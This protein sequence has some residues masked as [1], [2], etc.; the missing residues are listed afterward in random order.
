MLFKDAKVEF[1]NVVV[2]DTVE[3]QLVDLQ[4]G[5]EDYQK[6]DLYLPKK[7][8]SLPIILDLQGG[9]LIRGRKSTSKLGPSLKFTAAGYA[10]ASMNYSLISE[11]SFS[12]PKQVAEIRLVLAALK[13]QAEEHHLDDTKVILVG[14]S[15][16]AQLALLTAATLSA[17]VKLGR[18]KQVEP[19]LKTLPNVAKVIANYGPYE[20]DRFAA[21]FKS[22]NLE[23]KYQESGKQNSFEGLALGGLAVNENPIGVSQANPAN[24]FTKA[25]PPILAYAGTADVVVP[26][27]QSQEMIE[28]YREMTGNSATLRLIDG[29]HHG[30]TD[31][32]TPKIYQ[33]KLTFLEQ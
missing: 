33:E 6:Y 8:S 13:K 26:H 1:E 9:G 25:M 11:W 3:K 17:G 16:G 31:Y 29:G 7:Q 28:R 15:S 5:Q 32:D 14:E 2:P 22:D 18:L 30:I 4:Y 21:Q 12:F 27:E 24:Y 19:E 10:V 23:P 20:F